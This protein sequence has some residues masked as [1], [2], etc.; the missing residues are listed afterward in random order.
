LLIVGQ[1]NHILA[2]ISKVFIEIGGHVSNVVDTSVQ[3]AALTKIVDA[4]QQGFLLPLALAMS[5]RPALLLL[6]ANREVGDYLRR[7]WAVR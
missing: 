1:H 5:I 6:M 4:N 7:Y 2:F 3:L